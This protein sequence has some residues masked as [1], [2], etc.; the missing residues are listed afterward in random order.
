MEIMNFAA[1]LVT[2]DQINIPT[3]DVTDVRVGTIYTFVFTVVGGVSVIVIILSGIKFITSQ[4]DPQAVAKARNSII[5]AAVGL[6]I[7]V[8]AFSIVTF[9][10][11][12][13]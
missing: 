11:N 13:I 8:A 2:K 7:S 4:G 1:G 9:V 3:T 10:I 6:A 5:Y 12:R